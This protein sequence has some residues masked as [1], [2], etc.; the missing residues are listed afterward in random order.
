M[1]FATQTAIAAEAPEK[2]REVKEKDN[3]KDWAIC[4]V[5]GRFEEFFCCLLQLLIIHIPEF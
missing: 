3:R 1:Y 4:S 2:G 5:I